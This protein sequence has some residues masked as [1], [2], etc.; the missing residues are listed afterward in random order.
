MPAHSQSGGIIDGA[1]TAAMLRHVCSAS[2]RLIAIDHSAI[3]RGTAVS[4]FEPG[5]AP[6]TSP[7]CGARCERRHGRHPSRSHRAPHLTGPTSSAA[8]VPALLSKS[9]VSYGSWVL[10]APGLR[11]PDIC[12]HRAVDHSG[13]SRTSALLWRDVV[14]PGLRA[15]SLVCAEG[16]AGQDWLVRHGQVE[17]LG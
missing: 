7:N 14:R 6:I 12:G 3:A 11:H 8:P 1:R 17:W 2:S 9:A 13:A 15:C 4:L 16:I 10:L 5:N